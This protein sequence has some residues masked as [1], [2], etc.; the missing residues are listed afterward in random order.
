MTLSD[1]SIKRP[2]FTTMMSLALLVIGGLGLSK[3]GVDLFPDVS[4]PFVT[5]STVYR[6][7]G[8]QE[9]ESQVVKPIEDAVAGISGVEAIQSFSREGFGIVFVQFKLS[10]SLDRAVQEVRDKVAA[11]QNRLPRESE[12]PKVARI[13]LGAA[14]ILTYAVSA[15]IPSTQLRQLITDKLEPA[16]AQVDGVAAVRAVGG[17]VREIRVDIDLPRAKAAGIA[18]AQVAERIGMENVDIPAGRLDLGPH[19]LSVRSVGQ[20]R[21]VDEIQKLPIARS[22]QTGTLISLNEIATVTDSVADKR[23]IA[24]LN[25]KEAVIVEVIKQPGVNTVE[26]AKAVKR[27]MLEM[28]AIV[29]SGFASSVLIDTS[30]F[31]EANADEVWIAL[32]FGG[33]MAILIILVFLLDLRGTMISAL[34]LPTSVVGT[35]FVMYALD[36]TLN[37]M[38]LLALSLAIVWLIDDAVVV[39]ES[40]TH[41][42]EQ[43]ESP[44]IAAS[45]GTRDVF[46]AVVATTASLVAVFVPVAFMPGLVGQFF[47]QFGVTISAAVLISMFISFT[48]DPML[49]ARF[50]KQ[51]K[52]G[53]HAKENRVARS[54]RQFFEANER[55]Y[56]RSLKWTLRNPWKTAAVTLA[57]IVIALAA[58]SRLGNDFMTPEDRAQFIVE[59]K[60]P[61]GSSLSE[62]VARGEMAE[63]RLRKLPDVTDLYTLA[64]ASPDGFGGDANRV[65]FRVLVKPRADRSVALPKIKEAARQ[66]LSDLPATEIAII[67]PPQIEGLGDFFPIMLYVMGS[68]F[69]VISNEARRVAEILRE[70]RDEHGRSMAADIRIVENPAKPELSVNIDRQR[71]NETG[72]TSAMLGMQ[73]R[74]AMNGQI[75]GKL[76]QGSTETDIVVRLSEADRSTPEALRSLD[77]FTP[78]GSRSLNDVAT[79]EMT[80]TPSVI[81]HFNRERRVMLIA[82]PAEGVSLGAV[83]SRLKAELNSAPPPPGYSFFTMAK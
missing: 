25:G 4:F 69:E 10:M 9:I 52:P 54:L 78:T 24:R 19:E 37:Q 65:R 12:T 13:D 74:L 58:A 20:F 22:S 48:L 72:L 6:G 55:L 53:E 43:G 51:R 76:R 61:V 11:I 28:P 21:S 64:G 66:V 17:D 77:I 42:L 41:R 36:Y 49:S 40:I 71:A 18:P 32:G 39:R 45:H 26:V 80:S 7:A 62:S 60:L 8:P 81:E 1:I 30:I 23:T 33:F 82:S 46:L 2:V 35:F 5:I 57:V 29:G 79:F 70:M 67:E 47:K 59:L 15:Q 44:A 3:L 50:A 16:L 27:K 34:A 75:A 63:E 31:I 38:T 68:D 14:P 56:E 73:M 83:A